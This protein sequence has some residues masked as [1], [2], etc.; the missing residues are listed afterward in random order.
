MSNET[1]H[2]DFS[3]VS[4]TML[5]HF[6]TSRADFARYYVTQEDSPPQPTKQ[7][8]V[9]TAIHAAL[10]ES[11]PI[12]E[13]CVAYDDTC[14][15]SNGHLNPKPAGEFR[16]LHA[17]KIVM[18]QHELTVV[19]NAISSVEAHPLQE[20]LS[21]PDAKFEQIVTWT[22]ADSGLKCRCMVDF[23]IDLDDRVLAYDLKT[24]E[25]I[26]PAQVAR[27][28]KRLRY[29][30]QD[31]HYSSGLATVFGKPA[32]FRFWFLEVNHP[33][34]ISPKEYAPQSRETATEAYRRTM[35]DL[36]RC[37]E[38]GNWCD[39]WTERVTQLHLGPWDV[40]LPEQELEG[41]DDD[42]EE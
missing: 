13:V 9:G 26:Y 37:Y 2:Q 22:D 31:S 4:K 40:D 36:A 27:T 17:D 41:F 5:G 24:T 12:D 35:G 19:Q 33:H 14:F 29:W 3:R 25:Q 34:R 18:K 8:N 16:E 20:L 6:M 11:K 30:L 38:T 7:M 39:E 10:L 28:A 42:D 23:F 32:E 1:Y 15:K 21:H